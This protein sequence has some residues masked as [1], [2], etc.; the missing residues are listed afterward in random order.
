MVRREQAE[1][2]FTRLLLENIRRDNHPSVTQMNM[3]EQNIPPS[4]V[5]EY[6]TVLLEK[7]GADS[8][9]SVSMLQRYQRVAQ[10]LPR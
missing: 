10:S 2:V 1:A 7:L 3:L 8:V 9:P 4:L 6:L 5:G